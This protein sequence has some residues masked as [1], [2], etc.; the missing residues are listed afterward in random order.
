MTVKDLKKKLEEFDENLEVRLYMADG[1]NL[2]CYDYPL[3]ETMTTHEKGQVV[4]Y[5]KVDWEKERNYD[6]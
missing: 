3:N 2:K 6:Y 1:E 4:F 5:P